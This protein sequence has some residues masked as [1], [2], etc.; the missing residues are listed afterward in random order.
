[1]ELTL[2][3]KREREVLAVL[4]IRSRWYCRSCCLASEPRPE[5][6][7]EVIERELRGEGGAG[8]ESLD[9]KFAGWYLG[10]PGRLR[11]CAGALAFWLLLIEGE[12]TDILGERGEEGL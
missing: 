9:G 6:G 3:E 7:C 2:D 1:M 10:R 5:R 12:A 4:L 8:L 11:L